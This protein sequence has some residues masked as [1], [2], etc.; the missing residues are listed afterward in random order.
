M[1]KLIKKEDVDKF[2]GGVAD[3]SFHMVRG[4]AVI[5]GV[6]D[7][8]LEFTNN[9][10]IRRFA[11]FRHIR[12]GYDVD[13]EENMILNHSFNQRAELNPGELQQFLDYLNNRNN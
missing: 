13:E 7:G 1:A 6:T 9:N 3:Y 10:M 4:A 2:S 11:E 5:P 12:Y 8:I